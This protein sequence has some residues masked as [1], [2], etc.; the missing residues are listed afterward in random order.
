MISTLILF[1]SLAEIIFGLG[2]HLTLEVAI[3]YFFPWFFSRQ[4]LQMTKKKFKLSKIIWSKYV[5]TRKDHLPRN[6]KR[7]CKNRH[8]QYVDKNFLDILASIPRH[9]GKFH[10]LPI[11]RG[12]L[13]NMSRIYIPR[14][15]G[16]PFWIPRHIGIP[17]LW[18]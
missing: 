16:S 4:V 3:Y 9:I 1:W 14:H 11:S 6:L 15:I 7:K 17:R 10:D 18:I 13:A 8:F 12:I 2:H 5:R